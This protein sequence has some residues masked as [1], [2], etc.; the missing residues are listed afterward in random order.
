MRLLTKENKAGTLDRPSAAVRPALQHETGTTAML[1]PLLNLLFLACF[2][3]A[4]SLALQ[5]LR[6]SRG[7]IVAALFGRGGF[8]RLPRLSGV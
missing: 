5:Q 7:A 8:K 6:D 2:W 3:I 4:G 1:G